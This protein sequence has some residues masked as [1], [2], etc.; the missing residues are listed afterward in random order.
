VRLPVGPLEYLRA[1]MCM[2][3]MTLEVLEA[4]EGTRAYCACKVLAIANSMV[5]SGCNLMVPSGCQQHTSRMNMGSEYLKSALVANV[6]PQ[7]SSMHKNSGG[8]SV[9]ERRGDGVDVVPS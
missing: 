5:P 3:Y 2:S 4:T 9:S 8:D 1:Y 7:C 6:R